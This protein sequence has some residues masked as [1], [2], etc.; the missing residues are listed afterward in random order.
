V[1]VPWRYGL[2][3]RLSLSG[4]GISKIA[5]SQAETSVDF[6][7]RSRMVTWLIGGLNFQIEHHLLLEE[8]NDRQIQGTVSIA[9]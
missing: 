4:R 1:L 2:L 6:A 3:L 9:A 7:R 5:I 8:I